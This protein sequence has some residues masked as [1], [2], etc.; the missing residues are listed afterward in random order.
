MGKLEKQ[1]EDKF[2]ELF[3]RFD[4]LENFNLSPKIWQWI[5]ENF[6]P[7][8][9]NSMKKIFS[10]QKELEKYYYYLTVISDT[11]TKKYKCLGS[12]HTKKAAEEAAEF[13][14]T[15]WLMSCSV[16]TRAKFKRK[17]KDIK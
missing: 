16:M 15:Y 6:E 17:N 7:K 5:T 14:R 8:K 13:V 9:A 11:S 3:G 1:F 4:D 10:Q 2:G 12:Y